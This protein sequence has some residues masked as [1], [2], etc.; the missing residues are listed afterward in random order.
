[1]VQNL[2]LTLQIVK[3]IEVQSMKGIQLCFRRRAMFASSAT[4]LREY[5]RR[6]R[7]GRSSR[8]LCNAQNRA[9]DVR[10]GLTPPLS[11]SLRAHSSPIGDLLVRFMLGVRAT[12][13]IHFTGADVESAATLAPNVGALP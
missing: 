13:Q 5:L 10:S 2:A 9:I 3:A 11:P 7:S 6:S 4:R 1:M 8:A 12:T